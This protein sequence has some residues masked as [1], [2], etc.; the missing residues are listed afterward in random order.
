MLKNIALFFTGTF[1]IVIVFGLILPSN[2]EITRTV[3]INAPTEE[4]HNHLNDLSQ[5]PKWAPWH[6]ASEKVDIQLG[7]ISQGA[8]ATQEWTGG[9]GKGYLEITQSSPTNGLDYLLRFGNDEQDTKGKFSY[10]SKSD[11]TDVSWSMA[12]E[13]TIPVIGPYAVMIMDTMAG[14][15]LEKGLEKLKGVVENPT[16]NTVATE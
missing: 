7:E 9:E 6:S 12:G 5:W 2:Y 16:T 3:T 13:M 11:Q 14:P 10:Q 1:V 15:M 8:G 4:I